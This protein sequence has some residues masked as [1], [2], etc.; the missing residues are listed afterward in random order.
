MRYASATL[1]ALLLGACS[2]PPGPEFDLFLLEAKFLPTDATLCISVDG[3]DFHELTLLQSKDAR[4]VSWR[5]CTRISDV[6]KGSFHTATGRP[7][8]FINLHNFRPGP[9]GAGEIE[10]DIYHHGLWAIHKNLAV[11][12]A[13]GV[14]VVSRVLVEPQ[15]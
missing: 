5:D 7:A 10:V 1:C 12:R 14:W 6:A 9:D 2:K 3:S 13:D 8:Y 15:A 11:Q 4:F